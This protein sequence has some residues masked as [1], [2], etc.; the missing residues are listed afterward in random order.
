MRVRCTELAP[1]LCYSWSR[2]PQVEY[3][4][5]KLPT[6]GLPEVYE[7]GMNEFGKVSAM[8][9]GQSARD[10]WRGCQWRAF[11]SEPAT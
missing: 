4:I 6:E 10:I 9:G 1:F 8:M 5:K 11:D 3:W 2:D 7:G